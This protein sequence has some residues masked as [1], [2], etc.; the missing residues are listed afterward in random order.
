M[1]NELPGRHDMV[2]VD[3]LNKRLD[4]GSLCDLLLAH[5]VGDVERIS[6][7]T[8]DDGVRIRSLLSAFVKVL[9]DDSLLT[10]ELAVKDDDYFARLNELDHLKK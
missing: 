1:R 5:S 3:D 10:G 2:V 4:T 6:F 9:D 7:N 8:S